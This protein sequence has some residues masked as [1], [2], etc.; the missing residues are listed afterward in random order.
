[1][2]AGMI[3][4]GCGPACEFNGIQFYEFTGKNTKGKI[5]TEK[6]FSEKKMKA[7][8]EKHLDKIQARGAAGD[9]TL[10]VKLP[11][12]GKDI[13]YGIMTGQMDSEVFQRT[14]LGRFNGK[15]FDIISEIK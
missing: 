1:V 10:W 13:E 9:E 5:V 3:S 12:K 14:G 6:V 15:K 4:Y 11:Q 7:F 2:L 8:Y